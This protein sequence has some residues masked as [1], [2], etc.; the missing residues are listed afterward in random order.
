MS[1]PKIPWLWQMFHC[2]QLVWL[3]QACIQT[4]A[5][6]T[7]EAIAPPTFLHSKKKKGRQREKRKGFKA[8]TIKRLSPRSKYY[9]F[10][11][12]RATRIQNCFGRPTMVADNTFQCSM[13]HHFEI[14]FTGPANLWCWVCIA[15]CSWKQHKSTSI[16]SYLVKNH[17]SMVSEEPLQC[18][19]FESLKWL[20]HLVFFSK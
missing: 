17:Y 3:C 11:H 18:Q 13:A 10:N 6:D 1:Y 14:H 20:A 7:G 5:G 19:S 2:W 12:S 4:R 15:L 16:I 8:E 9:C